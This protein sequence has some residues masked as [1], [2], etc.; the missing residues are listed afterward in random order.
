MT[1]SLCRKQKLAD[2]FILCG[3]AVPKHHSSVHQ[4]HVAN[5]GN[6]LYIK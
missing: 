5:E 4:L 3:D 1:D 6:L 2:S